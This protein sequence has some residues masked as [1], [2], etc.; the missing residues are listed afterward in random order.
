M[1]LKHLKILALSTPRANLLGR[2]LGG[3]P[4]GHGKVFVNAAQ[5][6]LVGFFGICRHV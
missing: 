4:S 5:K 2:Q 1:I 6:R 3:A